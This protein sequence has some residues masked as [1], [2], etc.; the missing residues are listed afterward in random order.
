MKKVLSNLSLRSLQSSDS[1]NSLK[2]L[3]KPDHIKCPICL[4]ETKDNKILKCRHGLCKECFKELKKTRP[5]KCPY[6][7]KEYGKP[8]LYIDPLFSTALSNGFTLG[9]L[10]V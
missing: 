4:M 9:G 2:D 8:L 7:R 10:S 5:Y 3:D 6:C 1:Y